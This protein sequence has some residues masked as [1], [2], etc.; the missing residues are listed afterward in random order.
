MQTAK[1]F[2]LRNEHIRDNLIE[3]VRNLP[4]QDDRPLE[5]T[6]QRYRKRRSLAQ[7]NAF[8]KII[9]EL[10]MSYAEQTGQWF[11][12]ATWKE[13]V[14]RELLG[15]TSAEINGKVV[16]ITKPTSS[17]SVVEFSD[18]LEQ[19]PPWAW[20]NFEIDVMLPNEWPEAMGQP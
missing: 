18:L 4:A 10:A 2:V 6:I 11:S 8:H 5:V 20:D 13:L 3:Y 19:I 12:E 15:S 14:K 17:L 16:T 1:R 7:N 9:H